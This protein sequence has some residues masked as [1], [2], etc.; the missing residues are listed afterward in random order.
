MVP[1]CGSDTFVPPPPDELRATGDG[2]PPPVAPPSTPDTL[3]G[4]VSTAKGVELILKRHDTD[5]GGTIAS[6]ARTQAGF[7]A[8]RLRI[9]HPGEGPEGKSALSADPARQLE[10]VREAVARRPMALIVEPADPADR[11]LAQAVE[12]AR[13]QGVPVVMIGQ[14][15]AG[16]GAE[17]SAPQKGA[18]GVAGRGQVPGGGSGP[19]PPARTKGPLIVVTPP[20]FTSSA[21]QLIASA[22]R[23]AAN[24]GLEAR[25]GA[26]LL[27]NTVSDSFADGRVAALRRALEE[28]GIS[29][30]EEVRFAQAI[31]QGAKL[32]TERLKA[33]PKIAI[34]LTSDIQAMA[35]ARQV[36]TDLKQ[37]RPF[38]CAGYTSD[39]NVAN[40]VR[41]GT[42][43]AAAEFVPTKL[44]RKAISIGVAAARGRDVPPRVEL[45]I[46]V[47]DSPPTT[48]MSKPQYPPGA[49]PGRPEKG[50]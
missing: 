24:A 18:Q 5:E 4:T 42:V 12:E 32:L 31:E 48:G 6:G 33:S 50:G 3:T 28:A 25:A 27:I 36:D 43:A 37:Q 16:T 49:R 22:L 40:V 14:W 47:H 9:S 11:G 44:V 2:L 23:N 45:D 34:V 13:G 39:E 10:L 29:K 46:P 7:D 17:S 19:T 1:G 8:I 26:I 35:V 20:V 30:V 38:I 21:R 15:P 41:I